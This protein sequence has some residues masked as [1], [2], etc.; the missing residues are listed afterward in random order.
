MAVVLGLH[1][2]LAAGLLQL[3]AWKDRHG[4]PP[5]HA[6]LLVWLL[7]QKPQRAA[8]PAAAA[9]PRTPPATAA[10]RPDALHRRPVPSVPGEPHAITLPAAASTAQPA[11]VAPL[12]QAAPAASAASAPLNLALPR[13]ASS[14]WRTRNPA[15]DDPRTASQKPTVESRIAVALGGSDNITEEPL[16]DGRIRMR[17]GKSC[18]V[19]VPNRAQTLD[20]F[21]AS[22][23]PKA[24]VADKC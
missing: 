14:P 12:A 18:V 22:A 11:P 23:M 7:D 20:P 13:G 9:R 2:L 3:G 21:N 4:P 8:A 15:L 5:M 16:G 19:V 1:G 17:R 6:P 24:R 10:Q